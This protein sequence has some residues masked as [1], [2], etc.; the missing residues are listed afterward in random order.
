MWAV[1]G[2]RAAGGGATRPETAMKAVAAF[3]EFSVD[4]ALDPLIEVRFELVRAFLRES[5]IGYRFVDRL[6]LQRSR[7]PRRDR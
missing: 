1:E 6:S 5:T 4:E 2:R 7:G 3:G